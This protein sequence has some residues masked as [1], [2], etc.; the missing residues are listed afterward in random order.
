MASSALK[1]LATGPPDARREEIIRLCSTGRVKEALHRRFRQCLWSEPGLFSHIFRA[2]RALPLLRQLHAFAATSGAAADR[3]TANHLLLAY[4]DLGDFLAARG[5]F[6]RI[7]KRNV[8]SWNILIGGYVK[9][10]DLETARKLFDEMPARNVATWNAMVAGLTN[11]GL[12]EESLR[13]FLAM[14]REGMQ[15]DE[16]GLGSLFRC[17]AGLRDV[18]SGRQVH[19][20][21]VRS[22]LDRDMCVG[23]SLAHMY[24]RCGFLRDGEAA[25]RALPLLNIVSCNTI[26][27]GRT[28]NG[29]S[30]GALEYF[31][32]MRG[33]GVE[34]NAI[35][36]VS[37]VSS[38]SD[39]AALAQ[40]QQVHAQAIKAGV[41]KVV[42][43]MTSLVHMYSRCGC[44]CDSERVC[45]GYSG[46][47]L[48]LC[49]AMISA[50]GFHG[51][52]QKAVGLFKQMIAGG[53]E[54]NE[55]TFL[56]LLYACSHSGLKD[57]GMSCF[58]LMTNTCGLKPSVKHY[59]CIVDLLGRSGCLNEAEDL[60][61]SMPVQPDG[62]IWKT[63]LSACKIQKNFDMA[64]R[65]AERVIELDPHDSASYVLL[66]NI[67]ATSSRWEDVSKVRKTMREQ[68][69]RKE[70]GV[71]WVEL[72]GQI[73]QFCTGDKSHSRQRE[74]DEC[75]EEMMT[76]IRQCG[77]APDMSMV[78]HDME[79]EEKEVSLAH[80]SEKLA[81]AFAFLSLPEGVPIRVMKN[82]RVCDDC[83]VAI[84]LM[85]KV[86]G[87]EIVVRDVDTFDEELD[88]TMII[89][90][91]FEKTQAEV[92]LAAADGDPNVAIEILM[93]QQG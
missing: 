23:S 69:V 45:L 92:A 39:L 85:S 53:A 46:T 25:L 17:C 21:V 87:R 47:D 35:T 59:T 67:R 82:L 54:P 5:L 79:D 42:P 15:P 43:V 66:S 60:I 65:I 16:F 3:F 27:A 13:F 75:L 74:I 44:L 8:M 84:K 26:I 80:H 76:K 70:P 61:L 41:D 48:V 31:C 24:M 19:S 34:A 28:Q 90:M 64:E 29:D 11:S 83:H 1:K 14:R 68:N 2:C 20:Y 72:K 57:E 9:N 6:D 71:S 7:P 58:E 33:A 40:G 86:T 37:A 18:V 73:H 78:F 22:G 93:S 81:I 89:G 56:T 4:A 49:S 10:G 51:H 62:V 52:G 36:F 55:V 91:G 77:Y 12:N 32:M 38:C 63:L 50:Y 88:S 30:E